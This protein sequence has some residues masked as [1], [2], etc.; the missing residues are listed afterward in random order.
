MYSNSFFKLVTTFFS[1]IIRPKK[2]NNEYNRYYIRIRTILGVAPMTIHEQ[3][4]TWCSSI[5]DS[6]KVGRT[7]PWRKRRCQW[8]SLISSSAFRTLR[9]KYWTGTTGYYQWSTF[10]LWWYYSWDISLSRYN[11]TNHLKLRKVTS[12]WLPHQLTA[13]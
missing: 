6:C 11:R 3:L 12:R 9:W 2:M 4:R 5:S 8:W 13:E 1:D 7:F 10:N